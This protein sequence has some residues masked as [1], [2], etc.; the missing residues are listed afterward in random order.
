MNESTTRPRLA[1]STRPLDRVLEASAA[2]MLI[3]FIVLV[4][5]T[6]SRLPDRIPIHFGFRGEPDGWGNRGMVVSLPMIAL[7]L[8]V[9]LTALARVPH[10]FNYPYPI[11]PANA[12]RQYRLATRLLLVLKNFLV[13][14][15]L[16]I[17]CGV[18]ATVMGLQRGL[19]IWFV[20]SAVVCIAGTLVWYVISAKRATHP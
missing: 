3:S 4:A 15:F 17:H 19:T 7:V 1:M 16:A 14:A 12:E 18:L 2:L 6:W 20:P 10:A 8:Y 9:I 13:L 11:T 5:V